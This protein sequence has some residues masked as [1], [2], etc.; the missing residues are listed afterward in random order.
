MFW[1]CC[2]DTSVRKL[3]R[4]GAYRSDT[5]DITVYRS[6]E[7]IVVSLLNKMLGVVLWSNATWLVDLYFL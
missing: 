4:I 6:C 7:W 5:C 1:E 2:D 3:G